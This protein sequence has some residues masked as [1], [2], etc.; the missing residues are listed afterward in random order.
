MMERVRCGDSK[1]VSE[2]THADCNETLNGPIASQVHF[3]KEMAQS[4]YTQIPKIVR[5][6]QFGGWLFPVTLQTGPTHSHSRKWLP[7]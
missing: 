6:P 3:C 5:L 4:H 7:F 2:R 1:R